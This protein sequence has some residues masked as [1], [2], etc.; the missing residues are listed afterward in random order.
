[1]SLSDR[2][3]MLFTFLIFGVIAVALAGAGVYLIAIWEWPHSLLALPALILSLG[4][5]SVILLI[6][7]EFRQ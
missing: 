6:W 7:E 1:M 5:V 2:V 4:P 3:F